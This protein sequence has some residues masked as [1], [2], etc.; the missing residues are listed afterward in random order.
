ML[1]KF[2]NWFSKSEFDELET[3]KQIPKNIEVKFLLKVD[4]I[5]IGLLYC[6]EGEW[7]FKYA[8]DF[9]Q[10]TA[11]YNHIV[12]FPDIDKV[13]QSEALWPFF[14]VRIPGLKQP[15]IQE[16]IKSEKIDTANEAALLKRFGITTISNPYT[17]VAVA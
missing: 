9:K 8:N 11:V 6:N 14:K 5:D 2:K 15:A 16:I 4:N 3:T 13:Y 17:L 12:G 1:S 10:H 7:T